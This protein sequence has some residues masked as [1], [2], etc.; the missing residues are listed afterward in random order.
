LTLQMHSKHFD[1]LRN[2]GEPV[3][4]FANLSNPYGSIDLLP[5]AAKWG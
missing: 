5:V 4:V 3:G 2:A 1:Y